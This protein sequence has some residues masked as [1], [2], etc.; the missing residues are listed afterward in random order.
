MATVTKP[1]AL[2]ESINTTEQTP[3]NIADVLAEELKGIADNI[4]PPNAEDIAYD[5]TASGLTATNVQDAID[6]VISSQADV[7]ADTMADL[8]EN[9]TATIT[10]GVADFETI[11]GSLVKSLVVSIEPSQ[12]GS[13]TPSPSNIRPITGW[14]QEDVTVVGK[15]QTPSDAGTQTA[16]G[17]TFTVQSDG[18]VL[19]NGT[20]TANTSY[21]LVASGTST[22]AEYLKDGQNYVLTG[23]PS[24]GS[25][26][27]YSLQAQVNGSWKSDNGDGVSFSYTSGGADRLRIYIANGTTVDN[28]VFNAMIRLATSSADFEPYK[29]KT[30]TTPFNQTVYGGT[31]DVLTGELTIDR[32]LTTLDGSE[33]YEANNRDGYTIYNVLPSAGTAVETE[34]NEFDFVAFNSGLTGIVLGNSNRHLYFIN[35]NGNVSGVSDVATW[36]TWLSN[37]PCQITIPLTTPTTITLTPQTVKSL[38]G[39]NHISASTGEVIECKF[40]MLING[41]DLEML[42]S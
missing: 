7:I 42:L 39:E 15:N 26:S 12:S 23:C 32:T 9:K 6:E 8:T 16:T 31:L 18:S 25:G 2:D 21:Y 11:D 37:N 19:V 4:L 14:T 29:G 38:V 10:D 41:D 28:L 1:I 13:G 34:C 20:A 27:T 40:S 3:R 17:I 36:K 33:T 22:L 35:I 5:N 24:G 30:Y